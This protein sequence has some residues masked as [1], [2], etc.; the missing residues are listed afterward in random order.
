MPAS[1]QSI[2]SSLRSSC[3]DKKLDYNVLRYMYLRPK[4]KYGMNQ[5]CRRGVQ[6]QHIPC[7]YLFDFS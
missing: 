6:R 5:K 4:S 2:D 1:E 3:T 7:H